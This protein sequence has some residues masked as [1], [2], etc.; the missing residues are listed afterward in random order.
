VYEKG[1]QIIAFASQKKI[2]NT[3]HDRSEQTNKQSTMNMSVAF[4]FT[5][6]IF[7]GQQDMCFFGG[8][9]NGS[10]SMGIACVCPEGYGHDFL[11]F[12]SPNC[13]VPN[14]STEIATGIFSLLWL[15][16]LVWLLRRVSQLE[17]K[18]AIWLAKA[19]LL[20]HCSLELC[21]AGLAVQDGAYE[22]SIIGL[23]L[24]LCSTT[25]L[26]KLVI[27]QMFEFVRIVLD[28]HIRRMERVLNFTL[29]FDFMLILVLGILCIWWCRGEKLWKFD[30]V[31]TTLIAGHYIIVSMFS[32]TALK[33]TNEFIHVLEECRKRTDTATF[34]SERYAKL[35]SRVKH[36]KNRWLFGSI[37]L[38]LA[39]LFY[40]VLRLILGSIPFLWVF[41]FHYYALCLGGTI[42]IASLFPEYQKG[43]SS[44]QANRGPSQKIKHLDVSSAA[45]GNVVA[46]AVIYSY[47]EDSHH[48]PK[49]TMSTTES[50][51]GNPKAT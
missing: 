51:G 47:T 7:N 36:M 16:V 33:Y 28:A 13:V 11:L 38:S 46:T 3:V 14:G 9:C 29:G 17:K 26:M 44:E 40:V 49:S 1:Q 39:S 10:E 5:C 21:V 8:S 43:S 15:V 27:S 31:L 41:L 50:Q 35:T 6:T 32:L 48:E 4:E 23:C 12:H 42:G 25:V 2:K 22:M 19:L 24:F 20:Y 30:A 37:F 34:S 45:T 18:R